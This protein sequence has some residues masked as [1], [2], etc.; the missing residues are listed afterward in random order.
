MKRRVIGILLMC[1]T[2]GV[3]AT[4]CGKA[5][6]V[7]DEVTDT[8]TEESVAVQSEE[9]TAAEEIT[10][11]ASE[12]DVDLD[13]YESFS[14]ATD[15]LPDYEY[16]GPEAFYSELY[17][18]VEDL[19][20][21]YPEADVSI[22]CIRIVDMDE[23]DNSD[24]KVYGDFSIYNYNLAGDTL[25]CA[26]GGS[27]PG[28]IHVKLTEDEYEVTKFDAVEDGSN[29]TSSA[30]KLFGDKYDAFMEVLSDDDGREEIRAQIISN[31]V[32]AN[33]LDVKH[34]QDFGWDKKD[35]PEQNIDSFY[36]KLD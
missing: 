30:K 33:N 36:S 16:P 2:F 5:D 9:E 13:D 4:G 1:L 19:N 11:E 28:V 20:E 6:V 24:I 17:D 12:A 8:S 22:P 18:Y 25:L 31:Y 34:Y 10:E 32:F 26:S 27:Y 3:I 14:K 29:F 15:A 23:S 35:L 21:G 7:K